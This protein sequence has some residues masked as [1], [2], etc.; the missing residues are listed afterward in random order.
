MKSPNRLRK[1]ADFLRLNKQGEFSRAKGVSLIF[2]TREEDSAHGEKYIRFG[3]TASRKVGNAVKRNR[4]KRRLR[5]L[6]RTLGIGSIEKSLDIN[7]I[8]SKTTNEMD[9]NDL[10]RSARYLFKSNRILKS[11][12]NKSFERNR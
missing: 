12:S 11:S 3:V 9:W 2:R 1:R 4:A 10:L 6:I 8:A 5:A 7:M